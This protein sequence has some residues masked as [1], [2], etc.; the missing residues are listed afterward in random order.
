MEEQKHIKIADEVIVAIAKT[1]I[2]EAKGVMGMAN[3]YIFAERLGKRKR[4]V[5]LLIE[6]GRVR[7]S[8]A[9]LVQHGYRMQEVAADAQQKVKTAV[10]TMTGLTAT[11][12]NIHVA[13]LV[14]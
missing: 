8:I 3:H 5:T 1:A 9:L 2:M 12:V 14:A 6:N 13:G 11:E 4:G 10:E 7:I